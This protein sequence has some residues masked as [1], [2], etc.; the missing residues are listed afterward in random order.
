MSK[1]DAEQIAW[2]IKDISREF[3]DQAPLKSTVTRAL[4]LYAQSGKNLTEFLDALQ[5]A[6]LRTKQYTCN[7]KTDRL[8]DGR[9]PK[10]AYFFAVIEDLV[11]VRIN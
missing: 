6:R 3:A 8:D 5:A 7:I 4:R 11:G 1:E 9:K 2:V 10:I